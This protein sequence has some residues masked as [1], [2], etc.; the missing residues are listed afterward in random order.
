MWETFSPPVE[1]VDGDEK[2][3]G[4]PSVM[5]FF[6]T[7]LLIR[8]YKKMEFKLVTACLEGSLSQLRRS[9][10]INRPYKCI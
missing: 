3:V 7:D 8:R 2:D 4:E 9:L 10:A 5:L 1:C 6:G